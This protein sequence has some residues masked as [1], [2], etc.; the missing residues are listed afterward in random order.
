MDLIK[1]YHHTVR[2][3]KYERIFANEV[4]QD[5]LLDTFDSQSPTMPI[6]KQIHAE[7]DKLASDKLSSIFES[8]DEMSDSAESTNGSSS[9]SIFEA[10]HFYCLD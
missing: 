6:F 2:L 5:S 10:K 8:S 1:R 9:E 7:G 4:N 3:I